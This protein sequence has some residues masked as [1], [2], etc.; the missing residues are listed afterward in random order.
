MAVVTTQS[1]GMTS[2]ADGQVEYMLHRRTVDSDTQVGTNGVRTP[3][4]IFI[5]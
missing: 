1:M 4:V 3:I 2:L 5:H